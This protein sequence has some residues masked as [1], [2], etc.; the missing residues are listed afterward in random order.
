MNKIYEALHEDFLDLFET[1][2]SFRDLVYHLFSNEAIWKEKEYGRPD[3][4]ELDRIFELLWQWDAEF[5]AHDKRQCVISYIEN[6]PEIAFKNS[7]KDFN[8]L[9]EKVN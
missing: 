5:L 6:D 8:K 9:L 7:M 1:S 4:N 3:E 2:L